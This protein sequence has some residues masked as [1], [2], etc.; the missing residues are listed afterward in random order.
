MTQLVLAQ[1]EKREY[2]V[3][4]RLKA[5]GYSEELVFSVENAIAS[6]TEAYCGDVAL[7]EA[8]QEQAD[9]NVS[10]WNKEVLAQAQ[11]LDGWAGQALRD[12]LVDTSSENFSLVELLRVAWYEFITDALYSE[13]ETIAY[14]YMADL[15]NDGNGDLNCN[16]EEL[17]SALWRVAE[18]AN[19]DTSYYELEE[20]AALELAVSMG[21]PCEDMTNPIK[22]INELKG[23]TDS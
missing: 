13:I 23:N 10:I 2:H 19:A 20:S 16:L 8:I 22:T 14:N 3:M 15:L 4:N 9:A 18:S 11:D 12:G 1:V 21:K 6:V 5:D 17:E 7:S